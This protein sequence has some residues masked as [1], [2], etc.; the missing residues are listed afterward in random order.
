MALGLIGEKSGMTRIF[1]EEGSSIPVTVVEV[2]PNRVTQ[3]KS[4]ATDGYL[5]VQVTSGEQHRNRINKAM[6]G[7]FKKASL[8]TGRDLHEFRVD[9]E[10]VTDLALGGE[11]KVTLFE[12]GQRVDVTGTTIGKGFAGVI[13]RHHFRSGDATHGN[14]LAHRV[15]GS[16][17]QC[18]SPG[19]VFKG[20]RMAGHLGNARRTAQNLEVVRVDESR[21][22]ILIRGAVPG[23]KGGKVV[24]KPTT[25]VSK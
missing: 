11:I 25:R 18:Q 10:E 4:T 5:A 13:K 7:V 12:P 14:S 20:K 17:G 19:K 6:A 24:V 15:H 23:S 9:Q 21:N 1:T 8:E 22:L 3:L 2:Q 16:V